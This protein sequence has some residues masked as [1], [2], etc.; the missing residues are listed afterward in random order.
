[1]VIFL[2][3]LIETANHLVQDKMGASQEY[4]PETFVC[5]ASSLLPAADPRSLFLHDVRLARVACWITVA[6]GAEIKGRPL[7]NSKG[8]M[9]PRALQ[10]SQS[11]DNLR[12]N[13]RE[14]L[15]KRGRQE[16]IENRGGVPQVHCSPEN[17]PLS[18]PQ[19][20]AI[21]ESQSLTPPQPLLF[22]SHPT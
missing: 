14:V 4:P 11:K 5:R 7:P 17:P 3:F 20:D 6:A 9:K 15:P 10:G 1:M 18:R 21:A 13:I 19:I 12:I 16:N 8:E 2:T 22:P